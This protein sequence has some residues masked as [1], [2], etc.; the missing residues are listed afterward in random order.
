M[1]WNFFR[2]WGGIIYNFSKVWVQTHIF[3][4]EDLFLEKSDNFRW[5]KFKIFKKW[6]L[7]V[8]HPASREDHIPVRD[9]QILM[10]NIVH[11][12]SYY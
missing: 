6:G 5:E 2:D 12:K 1:H 4:F 9:D 3:D 7:E 11:W 10:I 8:A